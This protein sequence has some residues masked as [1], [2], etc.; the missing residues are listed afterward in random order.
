MRKMML[1]GQVIVLMSD[2]R[3][4][5]KRKV[6]VIMHEEKYGSAEMGKCAEAT[7]VE[8]T[9]ADLCNLKHCPPLG[10]CR[11]GKMC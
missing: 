10:A 4:K 2:L 7:Q 9:K 1:G 11:D 5:S 3:Q 8:L 6:K